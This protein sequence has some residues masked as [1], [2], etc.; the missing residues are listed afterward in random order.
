MIS[1]KTLILSSGKGR[2]LLIQVNQNPSISLRPLLAQNGL[3]W[4]GSRCPLPGVERKSDFEL[5]TSV[6]DPRRTSGVGQ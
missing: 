4:L 6:D 2:P 5:V 3:R 1:S